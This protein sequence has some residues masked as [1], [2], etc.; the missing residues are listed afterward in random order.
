[1]TVD[2]VLEAKESLSATMRGRESSVV[3]KLSSMPSKL[4][5]PLSLSPRFIGRRNS[6]PPGNDPEL[7][8]FMIGLQF[9]VTSDVMC[10]NLNALQ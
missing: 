5:L 6:E 9:S 4:M 3:A 7:N 8:K 2:A 1:M 10:W